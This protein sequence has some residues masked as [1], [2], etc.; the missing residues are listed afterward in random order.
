MTEKRNIVTHCE[1][2]DATSQNLWADGWL[3][4]D[5]QSPVHPNNPLGNA[6]LCNDCVKAR[7]AKLSSVMPVRG[8]TPVPERALL[9]RQAKRSYLPRG[10]DREELEIVSPE[11]SGLIGRVLDFIKTQNAESIRAYF[12]YKAYEEQKIAIE[13]LI[14]ETLR[15]TSALV[16]EDAEIAG[17]VGCSLHD[18]KRALYNLHRD[19]MA[20]PVG[21]NGW[22]FGAR[23]QVGSRFRR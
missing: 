9:P 20:Y 3:N 7:S 8:V 18:A 14:L 4:L 12:A 10:R 23:P 17:T 1:D 5:C 11:V 19:G 6:F 16:R 15:S 13:D 22:A 2:C 21:E